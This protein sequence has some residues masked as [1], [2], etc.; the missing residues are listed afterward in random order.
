MTHLISIVKQLLYVDIDKLR[1]MYKPRAWFG[2]K[3]FLISDCKSALLIIS[4][5]TKLGIP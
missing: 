4:T 2:I 1:Y 5:C 3:T